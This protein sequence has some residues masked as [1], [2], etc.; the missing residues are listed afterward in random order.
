[1]WRPPRLSGESQSEKKEEKKKKNQS[2][3]TE[4]T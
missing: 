2:N 1:M 4:W 3:E